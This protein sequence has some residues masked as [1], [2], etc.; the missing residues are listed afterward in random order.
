MSLL[1]FI[2]KNPTKTDKVSLGYIDQFYDRLFT[3]KK[4]KVKKSLRNWHLGRRIFAI[5][6]RLLY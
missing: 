2:E 3:P 1:E 4:N 6:E 5:M